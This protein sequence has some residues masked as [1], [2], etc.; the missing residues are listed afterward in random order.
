MWT[1]A[2]L[3]RPDEITRLVGDVQLKFGGV[4]ILVNNAGFNERRDGFVDIEYSAWSAVLAGNLTAPFLLS[5]AVVPGMAARGWGRIV[6]IGAVQA[7]LPLPGNA[8]YAAAKAGL[9]G[10]TR[11]MAVDLTPLGIV[12]NCIA[13][14]PVDP[15]AEPALLDDGS[16]PTLLG[17][18]G[19]PREVAQLAAFLASEAC[20]FVT[21]QT[22]TC[23]GGRTLF[24]GSDPAS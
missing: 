21:G 9:E 1:T 19:L 16:W 20:T 22:L 14:G 23:D 7:R 13:V 15:L 5:Q 2:D 6:H 11:A 8:A 10:L 3:T 24:R 17:R 4:D 18:R 12:V